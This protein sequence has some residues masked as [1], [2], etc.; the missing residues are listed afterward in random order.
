MV[1]GKRGGTSNCR[2]TKGEKSEYMPTDAEGT[3]HR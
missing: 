1:G 2:A 3:I